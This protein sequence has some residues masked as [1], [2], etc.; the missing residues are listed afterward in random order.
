MYVLPI[1]FLDLILRDIK[2]TASL[3]LFILYSQQIYAKISKAITCGK[4]NE[5][6]TFVYPETLL[7]LQPYDTGIRRAIE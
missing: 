5:S 6:A 7:T 1:A 3:P 4:S 2:V